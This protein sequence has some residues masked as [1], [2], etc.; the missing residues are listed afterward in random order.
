ME[1]L[2]NESTSFNKRISAWLNAISSIFQWSAPFLIACLLALSSTPLLARIQLGSLSN[3]RELVSETQTIT[4]GESLQLVPIGDN[5]TWTIS[6]LY[7]VVSGKGN[8]LNAYVF[9]KPGIY[10]ININENLV[11]K[12]GSCN[13]KHLPEA[14]KLTVSGVKMIFHHNKLHF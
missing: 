9:D 8:A 13:H 6:S 7:G 12:L 5:V 14:I 4:Y 10:Q 1:L 11:H 3:C 2:Y